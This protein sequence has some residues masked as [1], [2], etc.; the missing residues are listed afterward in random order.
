M[1]KVVSIFL[2]FF[3][4]DIDFKGPLINYYLGGYLTLNANPKVGVKPIERWAVTHHSFGMTMIKDFRL[5]LC[6]KTHFTVM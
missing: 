6:D 5:V 3:L 1:K 2:Y 4:C